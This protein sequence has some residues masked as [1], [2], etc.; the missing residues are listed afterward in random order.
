[1]LFHLKIK[2]MW[3]T[4]HQNNK[5]GSLF[6][7]PTWTYTLIV[8]IQYNIMYAGRGWAM[9]SPVISNFS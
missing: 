9:L 5:S 3:F 2:D 4:L 8:N 1:M 6:N 7:M